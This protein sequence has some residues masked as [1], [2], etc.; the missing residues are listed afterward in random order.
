[1]DV[2]GAND[3]RVRMTRVSLKLKTPLLGLTLPVGI[4][5]LG[6][7]IV[8]MPLAVAQQKPIVKVEAA[9]TGQLKRVVRQ[10]AVLAPYE[11]VTVRARV[12]GYAGKVLVDVGDSVRA[13]QKLVELEIPEMVAELAAAQAAVG[14]ADAEVTKANAGV[15]LN[16]VHF[17][18]THDLFDRGG[19]TQFQL[20]EAKAQLDLAVA[21]GKVAVARKDQA[22]AH[23]DEL[24]A[25]ARY[26]TVMA[27]FDGKVSMR[28]VDT[29][30]LVQAGTSDST[31]L[32]DV[33]RADV[34]RCQL[35]VPESDVYLVLQSYEGK[36]LSASVGIHALPGERLEFSPAELQKV[37]MRFS[38]TLH[39]ESHHML[40]EIL[41][42]NVDGRF[43]PGLF[44][45]VTLRARGLATQ[46]TIL[47]PNPAIQAPRKEKE[48]F[49]YVIMDDAGT[50]KVVRRVVK[51]GATDGSLYEVLDGLADGERVVVRGAGVLVDGQEV[52]VGNKEREES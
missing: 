28:H 33:V 44:A 14:T 8:R 4:I 31:P 34:L 21:E 11:M 32:F 43:I 6:I 23:V 40:A 42:S 19:R 16:Q 25:R 5:V 7:L 17:N 46:D 38:G 41:L 24:A 45:S 36:T 50:S 48:K 37:G 1:M 9:R 27:P 13:G 2:A 29:G 52:D 49:V 3:R 12:S 20:D 10:S 18:L 26:A 51:L 15:T 30:A 39:K 47:V 22:S 35:Y